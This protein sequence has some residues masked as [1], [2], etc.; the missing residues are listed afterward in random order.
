MEK[1]KKVMIL[2]K[3]PHGAGGGNPRIRAPHGA[4]GGNPR[5]RTPHGAGGGVSL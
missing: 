1:I 5:F 3:A 2:I 4:G